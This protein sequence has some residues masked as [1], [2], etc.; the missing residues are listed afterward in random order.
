MLLIKL[1]IMISVLIFVLTSLRFI[2][3]LIEQKQQENEFTIQAYE[4]I[5]VEEPWLGTYEHELLASAIY[6]EAGSNEFTDRHQQLVGQVIINRCNSSEFPNTIYG[7]L[8][9]EE[10]TRQYG[11]YESILANVGNRDLIPQRC[12]DNALIV[13]NG[14]VECPDNIVWQANFKQGSGVYEKFKTSY[15][16]TYFCYR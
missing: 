10:P 8:T 12:Y 9:Q 3:L 7:V 11:D 13:L 6:R 2:G 4:Q 14:E 16:T 15:G 5:P 1:A